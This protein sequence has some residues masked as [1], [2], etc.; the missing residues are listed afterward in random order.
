VT[1]NRPLDID[2]VIALGTDIPPS[3]LNLD[4]PP[5]LEEVITKCL[6]KTLELRYQRA[7]DIAAD[8]RRLKRDADL[9]DLVTFVDDAGAPNAAD[10]T[11]KARGA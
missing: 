4:I 9:N 3:R 6:E 7:S 2:A 5:R 10:Q 11:T 8:L 1:G